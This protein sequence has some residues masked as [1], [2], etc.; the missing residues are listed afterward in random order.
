MFT[1]VLCNPFSE[2]QIFGPHLRYFFRMAS[3]LIR[4]FEHRSSSAHSSPDQHTRLV[5]LINSDQWTA[6][7]QEKSTRFTLVKLVDN[8]VL[9]KEVPHKEI[10]YVED[11]PDHKSA[12]LTWSIFEF[13]GRD[14]SFSGRYFLYKRENK[15]YAFRHVELMETY[16][17]EWHFCSHQT[18]KSLPRSSHAE[19]P[20]PP[21]SSDNEIA[22]KN[23]ELAEFEQNYDFLSET[24]GDDPPVRTNVDPPPSNFGP[25]GEPSH[26][27]NP[28]R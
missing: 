2:I 3:K 15:K 23:N 24:I 17:Q 28:P 12:E 8:K 16:R 20:P 25:P 22:F 10:E 18:L 26:P 6:L 21:S 13:T 14:Q 27:Q 9:A 1:L 11:V 7:A 5:P 4:S 19:N